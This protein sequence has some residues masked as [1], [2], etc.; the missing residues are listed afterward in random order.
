MKT[1][2]LIR[3]KKTD[4]ETLGTIDFEGQHY[5]TIERPDKNNEPMVSCIP[6][7]TYHVT[8][9]MSPSRG[10]KTFRLVNVP[11]RS[12]ILIH[13]A[14]WAYQLMGC[15]ALG[16]TREMLADKM[17]VTASRAAVAKFEEQL[18]REPFDLEIVDC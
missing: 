4:T 12:G 18:K 10:E 16:L 17:A 7:G 6:A 2:R 13:P 5:E 14:N 3:D 15:I 1:V 9:E 11:G 8:Y